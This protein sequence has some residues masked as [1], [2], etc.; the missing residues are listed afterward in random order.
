[1][2]TRTSRTQESKIELE[3]DPERAPAAGGPDPG[4]PAAG[5]APELVDDAVDRARARRS[6]GELP[7]GWPDL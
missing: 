1:M 6:V 4:S 7:G 3:Q 2:S 5:L